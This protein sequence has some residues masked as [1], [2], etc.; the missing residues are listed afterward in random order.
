M[1]T[2]SNTD[3][4]Y[5]VYN[6]AVTKANFKAGNSVFTRFENTCYYR[7]SVSFDEE[8]PN[9]YVFKEYYHGATKSFTKINKYEVR[10]MMFDNSSVIRKEN[11]E[12][13]N[14]SERT[15]RN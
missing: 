12:L 14:V 1:V 13:W 15:E 6:A 11:C 5:G 7:Q 4:E 3:R 9:W 8:M 2:I 10:N